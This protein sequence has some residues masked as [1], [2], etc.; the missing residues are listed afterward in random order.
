MPSKGK[1]D[2]TLAV[3]EDK[4]S[5]VLKDMGVAHI[6]PNRICTNAMLAALSRAKPCQPELVG[7][8]H[9]FTC[10]RRHEQQ[11]MA[12]QILR[13]G[14]EMLMLY[15]MVGCIHNSLLKKPPRGKRG[16]YMNG[17]TNG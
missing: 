15:W 8:S 2:L 9:S 1:A 17:Q 14:I 7:Q 6:H 13:F 11:E 16:E 10:C 12:L 5:Q 3:V 4:P